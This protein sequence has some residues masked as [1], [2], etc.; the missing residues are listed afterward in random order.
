MT[1]VE[2]TRAELSALPST[3]AERAAFGFL[4]RYRN[5]HT[6]RGYQ[7]SLRQWFQWCET[8]DLDP[9]DAT[10]VHIEIYTRQ[11][12]VVEGNK[13]STIASKQNA[14]AGFYR[15]A[16]IDGLIDK[17]PM[18]HVARVT[19]PRDSTTQGLTAGELSRV[20]AAAAEQS[21]RLHA[22]LRLLGYNGMRISEALGIDVGDLGMDGGY[23]TVKILRKGGKRQTIPLSPPT[24]IAINDYR[25]DRMTGPL[26]VTSTGRRLTRNQVGKEIHRL[27][28][29]IGITKRIHPHSFR[30]AFITIALD[31]GVP[32]R[33]VQNSAGHSDARMIVVYDR[34][35]DSLSHNATHAVTARV[36]GMT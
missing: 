9:L 23:Y 5:E 31:A 33:D 18:I 12:E 3:P 14:L 1:Q 34:N 35:R 25:A 16:L 26:F 13:D 20:L 7:R 11:L 6:R 21:D 10:R 28:R 15:Y 22:L 30:H 4:L 24:M 17:D 8:Q 36:E 2:P 19:V 32:I 29:D 27:C